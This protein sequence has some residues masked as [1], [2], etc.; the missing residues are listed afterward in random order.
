MNEFPGLKCSFPRDITTS[1]ITPR[2]PSSYLHNSK[3]CWVCIRSASEMQ[4]QVQITVSGRCCEFL[5]HYETQALTGN[6]QIPGRGTKLLSFLVLS[7]KQTFQITWNLR[8]FFSFFS[9]Y[10][11]QS[12]KMKISQNLFHMERSILF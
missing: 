12:L 5:R 4:N 9:K 2:V 3:I 6:E 8:I 10:N 7:Y 1:S 11:S